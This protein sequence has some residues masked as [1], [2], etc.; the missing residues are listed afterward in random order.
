M[1][2]FTLLELLIVIGII[3]LLLGLLTPLL[4]SSREKGRRVSCQSNLRSIGSTLR[5]Y[6]VDNKG[7][8][9][10]SQGSNY[11]SHDDIRL[12]ST[13]DISTL[14]SPSLINSDVFHV[15]Y[16]AM[17]NV[18]LLLNPK[19]Y[20]CPSR[21]SHDISDDSYNAD[22]SSR[23]SIGTPSG[24]GTYGPDQSQTEL[25]YPYF[26]HNRASVKSSAGG[27]SGSRQLQRFLSTEYYSSEVS[28]SRDRVIN[29]GGYDYG[30]VLYGDGHVESKEISGGN[31]V[32]RDAVSR[33]DWLV[34][35]YKLSDIIL[36]NGTT[37][38][39]DD[40]GKYDPTSDPYEGNSVGLDVLGTIN[41]YEGFEGITNHDNK[42]ISIINRLYNGNPPHRP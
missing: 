2:K 36:P 17:H 24:A 15:G 27:D 22:L 38:S 11:V 1:K 6:S 7:K 26:V 14:I 42:T 21:T 34:Y 20:K 19:V 16:T 30:N 3:A 23:W 28:L 31:A 13:V 4:S 25:S 5:I 10:P 39:S 32:N 41:F 29:H 40:D 12:Y 18:N 8:L 35:H 9:P 33:D 37:R